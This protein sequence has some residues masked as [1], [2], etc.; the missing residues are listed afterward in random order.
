VPKADNHYAVGHCTPPRHTQFRKGQSGNPKGRPKGSQ[1]T[2]SILQK[3]ARQRVKVTSNCVSRLVSKLEAAATQ[4]SNQAASGNQRA[5][6]EFLS[7]LRLC[8]EPAQG[9]AISYEWFDVRKLP[10]P[11]EFGFDHDRVVNAC[12]R[13]LRLAKPSQL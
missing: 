3:V 2:S 9:E 5:I 10:P 12:L 1:N 13:L 7:L 4:L 8:E 11:E 6:R